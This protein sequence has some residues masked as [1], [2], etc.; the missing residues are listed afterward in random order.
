MTNSADQ[1]IWTSIVVRSMRTPHYLGTYTLA[2]K[3]IAMD[4]MGS[5]VSYK[6]FNWKVG[7]TNRQDGLDGC[8]I[9]V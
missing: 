3:D 2:I 8:F 9:D 6:E 7:W 5:L 4:E 1:I